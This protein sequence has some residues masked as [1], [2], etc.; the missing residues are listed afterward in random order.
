MKKLIVS[1][2]VI[3]CIVLMNQFPHTMLNPG[4][5]VEAH[6]NINN[7][8]LACHDPFSGISNDKCI[9]CHKLSSIGIDTL[10][11]NASNLLN[12]KV[13]F[14]QY[15]SNQK[16]SACHTDHK[17]EKPKMSLSSF[18]HEMLPAIVI[19]KCNSCHGQP[20][21]Q[22][23]KQV[24]T[25]CKNCHNTEGWKSSVTFNHDMIIGVDKNNCASCHKKPND[26]FHQ[27]VKENCDRCHS[28]NQWKPST[29]DHS[30][31]FQLDENHNAK[32]N[33]CHT[34][35]NFSAYTCYGCHEHSESNIRE[36]HDENGIYNYN[37]CVM[38]HKSGNEH[39][40]RMKENSN[41]ELNPKEIN[42]MKKYINKQENNNK[43]RDDK[44]ERD[45]D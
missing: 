16:C 28:T 24:T 11:V 15:L 29:F 32:C 31:H 44:K 39:D 13:L 35:N 19:S 27:Q 22:L 36:E 18:N 21:N 2:I 20:S 38:C 42:A 10:L 12:E 3:A 9:S 14:H 25:N 6:Q 5:L 7:K 26:T 1:G 37:N 30:V 45:D 23:H 34:N 33:S 17:G 8:C 4:D 40:I 43:D 41:Q